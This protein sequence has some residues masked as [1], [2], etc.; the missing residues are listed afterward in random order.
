MVDRRLHEKAAMTYTH[1]RAEITSLEDGAH[2]VIDIGDVDEQAARWWSA[3]LAPAQGWKATIFQNDEED[4]FVSPWSVDMDD[5]Q[6]LKIRWSKGN[7]ELS[8]AAHPPLE[9][10][11]SMRALE[12]LIEFCELHG[13]QSQLLAAIPVAM[14]LPIHNCYGILAT[15][16]SPIAEGHVRLP[17]VPDVK[18]A[19]LYEQIPYYMALSC[20]FQV[21]ISSLC[22]VLWEPDVPCNLVSPWLHPVLNELREALTS[23]V[24]PNY[25]ETLC[26]MCA[27]R[28]P[29]LAA[30]WLGATLSGLSPMVIEFIRSGTPPLDPSASAWTGCPQSF[31]D[32][33]GSGAYAKPTASGTRISRAD[34]W[35]FLYFPPIVDDDLHYNSPPFSPWEPVGGTT[36]EASAIRVRMHRDCPR[37][38]LIYRHWSWIRKDGSKTDDE[39]F[40]PSIIA[41]RPRLVNVP[42]GIEIIPQP[43]PDQE[44]SIAA[45]QEVFGWVTRNCEGHPPESIY[46]DRWLQEGETSEAY[47]SADGSS[48]SIDDDGEDAIDHNGEEAGCS[49]QKWIAGID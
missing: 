22:G 24:S 11:S 6:R 30:L 2:D 43:L 8:N 4:P 29:N 15:L 44:A 20:N 48:F 28:C 16:P 27:L 36:L 23:K 26:V 38:S 39:G 3:I 5:K 32:M 21:I 9:P 12:L 41:F 35:R 40:N 10:L 19:E 7:D 1:S 31:M 18:A 42:V 37:H 14:N 17:A 13:I 45:S 34:A 33:T 49:I 46:L 25:T 47:K